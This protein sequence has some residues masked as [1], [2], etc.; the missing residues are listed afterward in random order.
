MSS[1]YI[2][3]IVI[4]HDNFTGI[5]TGTIYSSPITNPRKPSP[6]PPSDEIQLQPTTINYR[7]LAP[8]TQFNQQLIDPGYA[9][10]LSHSVTYPSGLIS[11]YP[12]CCCWYWWLVVLSLDSPVPL[13][14]IPGSL[15]CSWHWW[16]RCCSMNCSVQFSFVLPSSECGECCGSSSSSK[17]GSLRR[18]VSQP[19][20]LT[21]S[22]GLT[23]LQLLHCH[24]RTE[25]I[26]PMVPDDAINSDKQIFQRQNR[27]S[28]RL[29][30][31][32]AMLVHIIIG[33]VANIVWG[34]CYISRIK[35]ASP[36]G[37]GHLAR[38]RMLALLG[39]V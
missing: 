10:P 24:C 22:M 4:R 30:L 7:F 1:L 26:V 11:K 8:H 27:F 36:G 37:E 35:D 18:T 34:L 3:I 38:I 17:E 2:V 15:F 16:W 5:N 9:T 19:Q 14:N 6:P 31:L 12:D 20:H 32:L 25:A 23:V 13:L 33:S 21:H 28:W 29:W 39:G